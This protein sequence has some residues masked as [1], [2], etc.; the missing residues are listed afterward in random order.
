[1][2]NNPTSIPFDR[3]DS[4]GFVIRRISGDQWHTGMLYIHE[5]KARLRHLCSHNH[6]EDEPAEE[7][8]Y[9]W[10]E[11]AAIGSINKRLIALRLGKGGK[12][13]VP[14]GVGFL[15]NG[16]YLD[17]QTLH[18]TKTELGMGLTCATYVMEILHTFGFKP[19][20]ISE[21]T[22]ND[23]DVHWQRSILQYFKQCHPDAEKHFETEQ[24]NI[25]SPRFH[26]QHVTGA[27]HAEEWPV[28][29]TDAELLATQVT[30]N[31]NAVFPQP[32][33]H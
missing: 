9:L 20:T 12:N 1:M 16:H 14:Y 11:V 10:T 13:K 30:I 27:G 25:G 26:P 23:G 29:K 32:L 7:L 3:A 24:Q 18:Y 19:F 15:D 6:L 2:L 28:S 5:G 8:H 31:Y 22:P 21:W 4:I 17:K 33:M